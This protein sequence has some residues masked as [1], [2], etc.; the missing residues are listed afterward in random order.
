MC[1]VLSLGTCHSLEAV[2]LTA[3]GPQLW[4]GFKKAYDFIDE[5]L[6]PLASGVLL[7]NLFHF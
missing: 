2:H 3:L 4:D 1:L 5:L 7:W 6:F